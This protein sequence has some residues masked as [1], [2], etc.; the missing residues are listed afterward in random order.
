M[1]LFTIEL[2]F[3]QKKPK[4]YKRQNEGYGDKACTNFRDLNEPDYDIECDSLQSFLLILYFYM[5]TNITC[6]HI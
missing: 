3:L 5:K 2:D 4:I 1:M 6:K